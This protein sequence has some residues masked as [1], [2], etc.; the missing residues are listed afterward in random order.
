MPNDTTILANES[1]TQY[2]GVNDSSGQVGSFPVVGMVVGKFK[3]G[4]LGKP[5]TIT[6]A[7][8]KG[9]LGYDVDNPNYVAVQDL[10]DSKKLCRYLIDHP[11]PQ[12]V[13]QNNETDP[14]FYKEWAC[15]RDLK[16]EN[17]SHDSD[18]SRD[19]RAHEAQ[20]YRGLHIDIFPYEGYMIPWLQR[21]AAKLS[22]NVNL[23]FAGVHPRLAQT[24]YDVLHHAVFPVFRLIGHLF[25]NPELYMHS[26][27][28]WFY[29]QNPK[30]IM[31][32][33]KDIVFE[34]HTFEGPADPGELCHIAYG[35]YMD[36][37]PRDKRDRHKVDIV[38]YD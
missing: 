24:A 12:Y 6:K 17:L 26:Y 13:L 23:H 5:M 35:N 38:F 33:H 7:N 37:P 11:H 32:P 28:A 29:E 36:L 4:C 18:D 25:G 3:R 15:L 34:G 16:S 10:L 30:R 19:R 2:Q 31:V 20:K 22:V 9:M 8:I 27:G 14:G 21:L 1:G